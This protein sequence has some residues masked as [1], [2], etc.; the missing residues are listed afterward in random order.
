[1]ER[2]SNIM[3]KKNTNLVICSNMDGPQGLYIKWNKHNNKSEKTRLV[4]KILK[5]S[6]ICMESLKISL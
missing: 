3:E 6:Y 5:I 2:E 1:M 4:R